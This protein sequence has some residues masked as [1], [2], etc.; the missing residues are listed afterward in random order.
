[1]T[2]SGGPQRLG[3]NLDRVLR[4]LGAPP[5]DTIQLVFDRWDEVVGAALAERTRPSGI[6]GQV[7]LLSVD[8]P[9]VA[10]HVRYLEPQLVARLGTLLGPDRITSIQVRVKPR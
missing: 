6:D 10:S 9:A 8:E 4:G 2:S 7:L 1:M 5:T 3:G